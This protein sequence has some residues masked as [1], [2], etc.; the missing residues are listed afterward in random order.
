MWANVDMEYAYP[1]RITLCQLA[2]IT[3]EPETEL[4]ILTFTR[5]GRERQWPRLTEVL[6]LKPSSV[7]LCSKRVH[8]AIRVVELVV[9][10]TS[11]HHDGKYGGHTTQTI[12]QSSIR[13]HSVESS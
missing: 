7:N 12:P 11:A 6:R 3:R 9:F 4:A 10:D 8:C 13:S 5:D 2:K 1:R